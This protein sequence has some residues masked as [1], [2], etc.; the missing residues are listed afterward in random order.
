MDFPGSGKGVRCQ[1]HSIGKSP[2]KHCAIL[3]NG[4]EDE[5]VR[6]KGSVTCFVKNRNMFSF[7]RSRRRRSR[8]IM[9]GPKP[10]P[11]PPGH[12]ILGRGQSHPKFHGSKLNLYFADF[13]AFSIYLE[14]EPMSECLCL[15]HLYALVVT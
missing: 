7:I 3:C 11:E 5:L 12:F 14:Y 6:H 1:Y 15:S 2:L 4:F 10:E 8:Y 13:S 9:P